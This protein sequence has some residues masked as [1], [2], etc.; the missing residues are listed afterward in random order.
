MQAAQNELITRIGPGTPCGDA[1]APLL[2]AGGAGRRIRP[3]LDPRMAHRPVKAVRLLG[4]DLV[5]FRDARGRWGLLDRDCPHRGADLA[6]ARHEGDGL[7]CPFHGW[8][9][10]VDRRLPGDA[11]RAD[12]CN[13]VPARAPAQLP[14]ARARGVLFAWLGPEGSTPPRAC[15]RWTAFARRPAQLRVQGPVALQ[16]AAGVRS[17]HRPG[18][19]VVPAPLP[20]RRGRCDESSK[21][22]GRQF[23]APASARSMASAGR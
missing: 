4:Q 22:Y 20:A 23:R 2:A 12:G 19:S 6:F 15:R 7:R 9:F 1:D 17:R 13:A 5:L 8:K 16:L 10:D 11:G 14:G 21:A 18:A 3:A